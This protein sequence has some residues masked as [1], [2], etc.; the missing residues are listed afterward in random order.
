MITVDAKGLACPM[1]LLKLKQALNT[2][3]AGEYVELLAT[4]A[5]SM[6][7]IR[8]YTEL[9]SHELIEAQGLDGVFRYV[10]KKG[11]A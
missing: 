8:S 9:S 3:P 2:L 5:G 7:D 1:P 6:R 4:D 11:S 10:V